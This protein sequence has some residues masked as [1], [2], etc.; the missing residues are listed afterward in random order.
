MVVP[1]KKGPGYDF[2]SYRSIAQY[3]RVMMDLYK[4]ISIS[5]S[6]YSDLLKKTTPWHIGQATILEF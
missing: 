1:Q 3:L 5:H 2:L 6:L 4:S